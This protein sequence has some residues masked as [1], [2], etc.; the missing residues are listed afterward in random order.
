MQAEAYPEYR[1][2]RESFSRMATYARSDLDFP[3]T[4]LYS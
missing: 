3:K 1:C 2:R 4:V